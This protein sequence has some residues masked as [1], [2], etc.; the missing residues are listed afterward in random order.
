MFEINTVDPF[1]KRKSKIIY[2]KSG[3]NKNSFVETPLRPIHPE[4]F[5]TYIGHY[6]P[7]ELP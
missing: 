5:P 6:T 2:I 7:T 1:E 3:S 4:S